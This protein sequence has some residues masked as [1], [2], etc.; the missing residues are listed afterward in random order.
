VSKHREWLFDSMQNVA[1]EREQGVYRMASEG[2]QLEAQRAAANLSQR[3]AAYER[4][5]VTK[6]REVLLERHSQ[7]LAEREA[8]ERERHEI[9]EASTHLAS[10]RDA[11]SAM[12]DET[13]S[14]RVH[15]S[16]LAKAR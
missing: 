5:V 8:A 7:L 15:V 6:E 12:A 1:S 3:N 2:A 13:E 9:H 14:Q 16:E 11:V 10:A 4:S